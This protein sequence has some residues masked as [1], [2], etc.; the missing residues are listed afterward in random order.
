[1]SLLQH[2]VRSATDPILQKILKL[3]RKP[4]KLEYNDH[5]YII[6]NILNKCTFVNEWEDLPDN[7]VKIVPRREARDELIKKYI[8]KIKN[9]A[10]I[11]TYVVNAYDKYQEG[12]KWKELLNNNL[13][14]NLNRKIYEPE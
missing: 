12:D 5:E 1:M 14:N 4:T 3:L 2:Y 9:D 10:S 6:N 13:I 7:V 8:I 11:D